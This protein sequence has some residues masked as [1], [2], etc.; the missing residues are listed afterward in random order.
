MSENAFQDLVIKKDAISIRVNQ[1]WNQ[2]SS[3]FPYGVAPPWLDSSYTAWEWIAGENKYIE[4]KTIK[5]WKAYWIKSDSTKFLPVSHL[6][7]IAT[8]RKP[9]RLR[10]S[11]GWELTVSLTGEESSDPDNFIGTLPKEFSKTIKNTSAEPPQAFGYP[12]LYFVNGQEK[13]AKLYAYSSAIPAKK[14]E[15][16]VGISPSDQAMKITVHNLSSLP[17]E[18]GVFWLDN[19]KMVNLREINTIAVEARGET[20]YGYIIATANPADIALYT[21]KFMLRPN[22]PNPF[23]RSTTL[24]FTVPY[25]WNKDGSKAE[26]D[27]QKI[28][29]NIY[30]ISGRLVAT[31]FSGYAKVGHHRKVWNGKSNSGRFLTSGLYIARLTGKDFSKSIKMFKVK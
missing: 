7:A 1:G 18:V 2:I 20:Q 15:W 4:A 28:S 29:L 16:K 24:E 5:P 19:S 22:Y 6:P 10:R 14:I 27:R 26:G 3:P 31:V 12:H 11:I 21:G 9:S 17:P 30:N 8:K 25:L 23:R 13:C